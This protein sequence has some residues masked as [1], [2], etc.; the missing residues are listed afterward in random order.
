MGPD[1]FEHLLPSPHRLPDFVRGEWIVVRDKFIDINQRR[2]VAIADDVLMRDAYLCIGRFDVL[3]DF[4]ARSPDALHAPAVAEK[5]AALRALVPA[6][7]VMIPVARVDGE[8]SSIIAPNTGQADLHELFGRAISLIFAEKADDAEVH[9]RFG[10]LP[11]PEAGEVVPILRPQPELECS[12]P[13]IKPLDGQLRQCYV[14]IDDP[15]SASDA[16]N[17]HVFDTLAFEVDGDVCVLVFSSRCCAQIVFEF[18]VER[19]VKKGAAVQ[20]IRLVEFEIALESLIDPGKQRAVV[21]Q[22]PLRA[23]TDFI[24]QSLEALVAGVAVADD[25]SAFA[26]SAEKVVA[27]VYFA[28][29]I[30]HLDAIESQ[31][32]P[33]R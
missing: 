11:G 31:A 14:R 1:R 30:S 25:E 23:E 32:R 27:V 24:D 29:V 20:E 6:G 8:A 22:T 33:E 7:N 15:P 16:I 2:Q 17:F 4:G 3:D 13:G 21:I 9:G 18:P 10:P 5:S 19:C 12:F 28:Q 26:D